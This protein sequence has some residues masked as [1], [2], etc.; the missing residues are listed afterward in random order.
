MLLKLSKF[1]IYASVFSVVIVLPQTFF[2]FIGG[3]YYFF[4]V[5]VEVSLAFFILYWAFAAPAGD[6]RRRLE[7]VFEK[8]LSIAVSVFVLMVLLSTIFAYDSH[9]AFWSNY[10]RGEGAFQMFHYYLFFFLL[11]ALFESGR[12]WHLLFKC[13]LMAAVFMILYGVAAAAGIDGF[14]GPYDSMAGGFWSKLFSNSRFQGSLGN[15][16]YVSPY[17]MFSMFF[18]LWLLARSGLTAW[19]RLPYIVS[20]SLSLLFFILAQT[21]GAFLGLAVAIPAFFIVLSATG[22]RMQKVVALG[23]ATVI[24][25]GAILFAVRNNPLVQRL[26]G[27]RLLELGN[28]QTFQTR[29]WTWGSAWQG[30]K[31]RPLLGWGLENFTAVFDKYFDPRHFRPGENTETWF[32]RSHSVVFGYLTEIGIFGFASYLAMFAVFYAQLLTRIVPFLSKKRERGKEVS[33]HPFHGALLAAVPVGYLIQG[34][35]LFD[36]LPIYINVFLFLAFAAYLFVS[37]EPVI[38]AASGFRIPKRQNPR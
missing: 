8:P 17:L 38:S 29:L 23:L 9:A 37:R 15:P 32:D 10:E 26:P 33:L 20:L 34:I 14:I 1:F 18:A 12:D 5:S 11:L 22:Q 6:V 31:E 19:R 13:S 3:K 30:F 7:R 2:P 24:G 35:A 27:G 21:R 28:V 16:A 25:I 4:R 36:V